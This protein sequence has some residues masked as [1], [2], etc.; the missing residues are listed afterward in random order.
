[1]TLAAMLY[2]FGI[3]FTFDFERLRLRWEGLSAILLIVVFLLLYSFF[4]YK[5][6]LCWYIVFFPVTLILFLYFSVRKEKMND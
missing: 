2:R 5:N 3:G 4:M 1:M 6:E